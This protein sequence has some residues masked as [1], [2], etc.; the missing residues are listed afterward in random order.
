M[1]LF[2]CFCIY[3]FSNFSKLSFLSFQWNSHERAELPGPPA[4]PTSSCPAKA[5][6][7]SSQDRQH[8]DLD[9]EHCLEPVERSHAIGSGGCHPFSGSRTQAPLSDIHSRVDQDSCQGLQQGTGH[10]MAR[11]RLASGNRAILEMGDLG[12]T[13]L[14]IIIIARVSPALSCIQRKS[15][16]SL[17]A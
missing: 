16:P 15:S 8:E 1:A 3:V 4:A 9:L 12:L 7:T 6:T 5:V 11:L 10:L 13:L 17:L 2:P 14:S